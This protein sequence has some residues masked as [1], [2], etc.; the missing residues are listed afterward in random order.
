M[1]I[2]KLLLLGSK[3]KKPQDYYHHT[4]LE[5]Y[6]EIAFSQLPIFES[7]EKRSFDEN[8]ISSLIHDHKQVGNFTELQWKYMSV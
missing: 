5:L 7:I 4:L 3:E 1:D 6:N 2:E 8:A